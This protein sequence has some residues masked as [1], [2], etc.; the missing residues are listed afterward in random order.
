MKRNNIVFAVPFLLIIGGL[1]YF[2]FLGERT[3]PEPVLPSPSNSSTI[4]E[5]NMVIMLQKF[6]V[7]MLNILMLQESGADK[8]SM[9][10]QFKT[11]IAELTSF[12]PKKIDFVQDFKSQNVVVGWTEEATE[13]V[14]NHKK[15]KCHYIR[16]YDESLDVN[17]YI[18]QEEPVKSRWFW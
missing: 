2:F 4:K 1:T 17:P 10:E 8:S 3:A 16:P 13:F 15:K 6:S 5:N 18:L 7:S 11:A 12:N 9:L 14:S